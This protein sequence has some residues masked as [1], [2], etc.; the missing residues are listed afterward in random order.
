M[1]WLSQFQKLYKSVIINKKNYL[2]MRVLTKITNATRR[3]LLGQLRPCSGGMFG[4]YFFFLHFTQAIFS[5]YNLRVSSPKGG[6]PIPEDRQ[7]LIREFVPG[8][9]AAP[10]RLTARPDRDLCKTG[11]IRTAPGIAVITPGKAAGALRRIRGGRPE[12]AFCP[13]CAFRGKV[14]S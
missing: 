1:F 14:W 2:S 6:I 9:Q 5:F 10:A 11:G 3:G 4:K 8:R 7:R 12:R 13:A